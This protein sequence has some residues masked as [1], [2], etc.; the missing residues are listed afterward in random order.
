MILNV[1]KTQQLGIKTIEH[2]SM[3]LIALLVIIFIGIGIGVFLY[4]KRN[5]SDIVLNILNVIETIPELVLLVILMPFLGIGFK[6]TMVASI[7][8]SILPVARNTYVGLTQVDQQYL[9]SARAMGLAE[10]E[11]L[12]HIRIPLALPLIAAGVRIAIVFTMG[13]I[14]LGGLIAAGG[15]GGPIQTGIHLYDKDII[16]VTGLWIGILAVLVDSIGSWIEKLLNRR[17]GYD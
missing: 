4:N 16:L 8:Y 9:E 2:L 14:T 11:I 10:K 17:Y 3:V 1:W 7:L 12:W 13:V 6:P 5:L 15:L